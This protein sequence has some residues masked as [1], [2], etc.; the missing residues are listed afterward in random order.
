MNEHLELYDKSMSKPEG[1][2]N[3]KLATHSIKIEDHV[4][5][6]VEKRL[7]AMNIGTQR[8]AQV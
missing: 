8:V 1:N 2:I 7:N 4:V 3:L 6:E 5:V